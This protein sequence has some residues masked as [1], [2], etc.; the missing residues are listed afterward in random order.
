MSRCEGNLTGERKRYISE[1]I[2][3]PRVTA[4]SV[5]VPYRCGGLCQ[6]LCTVTVTIL[7]V[8]QLCTLQ[9]TT[10]YVSQHF[11]SRHTTVYFVNLVH[12]QCDQEPD[13]N[14]CPNYFKLYIAF[15][16]STAT[17]DCVTLLS[18][19]MYFVQSQYRLIY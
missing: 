7:I 1:L 2:T 15:T 9:F 11:T 12:M 10:E 13:M 18:V 14:E 17:C 19:F 4:Q 16:F 6:C 3:P 8:N 5:C